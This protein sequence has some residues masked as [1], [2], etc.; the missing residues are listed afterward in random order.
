MVG[1]RFPL[2][3]NVVLLAVALTACTP[4]GP[5][6]V[7][8]GPA[9]GATPSAET[10]TAAAVTASTPSTPSPTTDCEGDACPTGGNEA[11]TTTIVIDSDETA[12]FS[13]PSGNIGCSLSGTGAVCEIAQHSFAAP[14]K[15]ADCDLDY[16]T[17]VA[18]GAA[19]TASFLC[20]GDTAFLQDAPVLDYGAQMSNGRLVCSSTRTA[21]ACS[22]LDGTHGFELSRAAYRLY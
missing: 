10:S 11:G 22:T 7:E 17:M 2:V 12:F 13:S 18:V 5:A 16:G 14:P 3:V 1:N 15:P 6:T 8:A 19:E 4:D 21:M 20:H 9:V